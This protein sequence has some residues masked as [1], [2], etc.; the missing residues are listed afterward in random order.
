MRIFALQILGYSYCISSNLPAVMDAPHCDAV[1]LQG[2]HSQEALE[3]V[4][5]HVRNLMGPAIM[6]NDSSFVKL[7]K[8]QAVQAS[9][10]N[11]P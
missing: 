2:I 4:K 1:H 5:N 3:M 8:L 6:H 9:S 11:S 10:V 7:P